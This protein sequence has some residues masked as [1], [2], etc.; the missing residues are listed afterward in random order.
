MPA[1]QL[2]RSSSYTRQLS[3]SRGERDDGHDQAA[4]GARA[5][6]PEQSDRGSPGWLGIHAQGR[7]RRPAQLPRSPTRP[8]RT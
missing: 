8:F 3:A 2:H 4:C 7:E 6:A 1:S 5:F